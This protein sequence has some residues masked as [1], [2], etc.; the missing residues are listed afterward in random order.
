MAILANITKAVDYVEPTIYYTYWIDSPDSKKK[1]LYQDESDSRVDTFR[2][3][4]KC[5]CT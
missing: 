3:A 5:T 2:I 4:N 1:C